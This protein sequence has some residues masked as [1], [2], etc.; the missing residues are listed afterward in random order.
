M[1]RG[2]DEQNIRIAIKLM[3]PDNELFEVRTIKGKKTYSGYFKSADTLIA[4]L[5]TNRNL[6]D[7]SQVYI[8]LN[9]IKE[10]CYSRQQH[11]K[12]LDYVATTSDDDIKAYDFLMLDLDPERPKEVSSSDDEI[13]EA[14]KI[15]NSIYKYMQSAGW[16]EPIVARSGNGVHL[17]YSINLENSG[18]AKTYVQNCL[19]VLDS[20]FSTDK[21]KVDKKVFNPSRICKLYGTVATK[22]ADTKERPHRMAQIVK[23]PAKIEP[24]NVD[25]I[26]N[27]AQSIQEEPT[28]KYFQGAAKSFDLDEFIDKYGIEVKE[29]VNSGGYTRYILDH[30]PFNPNHKGRDA[31]L[32]RSENGK[33]GFFCFHNSCADNHWKE[34]RKLYE[35]HAYDETYIYENQKHYTQK[36]PKAAQPNYTVPGYKVKEKPDKPIFLTTEEIRLESRPETI[37]I[38]SGIKII[39]KTVGGFEKG[40]I[41]LLSGLRAS[42]KSTLLGQMVLDAVDGGY[43]AAIYSGE[44]EPHNTYRWLINNAASVQHVEP[45]AIP[46]RYTVKPDIEICISKWLDKKVW[47]Y[48]NAYAKDYKTIST[49]L[50]NIANEKKIDLIVIDNLMALDISELNYDKFS[51]QSIFI[52]ELSDLAKRSNTHIILVAHPRKTTGMLRLEDVSGSNDIVNRVDNAFIIHRSG[53]DLEK[54]YKEL[55]KKIFDREFP[56]ATNLIEICK[57]REGGGQGEM[58]PLYYEEKTGRLKNKE[59]E[60][61]VYSWESTIPPEADKRP[62]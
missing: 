47:I 1:I 53:I 7:G 62:F 4:E 8:T 38:P 60:Q 51:A 32:T 50:E 10:E 35:P 29:K 61:K 13:K 21:V 28:P 22:G 30:C 39:D 36:L 42:G 40:K 6:P 23:A 16:T 44:L 33:L 5:K 52:S 31:M 15:A 54:R 45:T 24:T 26:K 27:L 18:N 49:A 58:I 59:Y 14:E 17:L 48:N 37:M 12:F 43:R 56:G 9:A 57:V 41:S 11:D 20:I 25:V 2:I 3:K 19:A 34:F 55:F 46:N